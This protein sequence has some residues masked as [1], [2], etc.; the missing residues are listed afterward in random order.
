[1][2][3]VTVQ[4]NRYNLSKLRRCHNCDLAYDKDLNCIPLDLTDGKGTESLREGRKLLAMCNYGEKSFVK[5][6]KYDKKVLSCFG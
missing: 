6:K 5:E 4:G 2:K 3:I 1:M